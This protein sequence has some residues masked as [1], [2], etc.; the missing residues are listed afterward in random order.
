MKAVRIADLKNQLSEH[1]RAV[2]RGEEVTVTDRARPIAR[3]VP[4][5]DAEVTL[6][7]AEVPFADVKG[8]EHR[9]ASWSGA[10]LELLQEERGTR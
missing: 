3:I 8:L 1:L 6:Q 10:S 4:L 2:E 9:R 7:A 5:D